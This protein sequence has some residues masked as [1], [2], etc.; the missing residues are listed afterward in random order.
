MPR[1]PKRDENGTV[2]ETAARPGGNGFDP[3]KV[4]GYFTR[5]DELDGQIEEIMRK[6]REDCQPHVDDFK[7]LVKEAS[8]AGGI[9]KKVF[10]AMAGKRRAL[11]KAENADHALSDEQKVT[12]EQLAHA[13]GLLRDTPLGAAALAAHPGAPEATAA[14]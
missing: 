14:L 12:F 2:H 13:L 6:A 10:R 3:D 7:E 9:P 11:R 1:K 5:A 8:E 4:Q